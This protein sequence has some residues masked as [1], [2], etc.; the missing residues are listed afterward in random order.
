MRSANFRLYVSLNK[1]E[2]PHSLG[3]H[4]PPPLWKG[5]LLAVDS[6]SLQT[7]TD[8]NAYAHLQ[9]NK[10]GMLLFIYSEFCKVI[11]AYSFLKI[12]I[13]FTLKCVNLSVQLEKLLTK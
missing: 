3:T 10:I 7:F 1:S 13:Y 2:N 4:L 9:V 6:M 12:E 8:T 11:R 5:L